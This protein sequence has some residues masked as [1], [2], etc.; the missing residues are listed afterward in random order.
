MK[1]KNNGLSKLLTFNSGHLYIL[2]CTL[3]C[4]PQ[5]INGNDGTKERGIECGYLDQQTRY[6]ASSMLSVLLFWGWYTVDDTCFHHFCSV[7]FGMCLF[8]VG[9]WHL[10]SLEDLYRH[11]LCFNLFVYDLFNLCETAYI[12]TSCDVHGDYPLNKELKVN[13]LHYDLPVWIYCLLYIGHMM[14]T[15][16]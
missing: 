6:M 15:I 16:L 5:T 12:N 10:T 11:S 7:A 1:K 8:N 9:S 3:I 14:N 2:Y 13:C 4:N